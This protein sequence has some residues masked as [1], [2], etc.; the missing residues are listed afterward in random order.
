MNSKY[1]SI[2]LWVAAMLLPVVAH[3]APAGEV[4]FAKGIGT[5]QASGNVPR[6]LSQGVAIEAGDTVTLGSNSFAVVK[7]T[8]GTQMTLRPNTTIKFDD[9][10][11]KQVDKPDSLIASLL[12]G[13]VRM[14][15][16][17][18]AKGSSSAAK[19]NTATATVGIRG[20]DFDARICRTDC[21][22]DSGRI[23]QKSDVANVAASAR[24]V[25]LQGPVSA[26]NQAG[27]H[28]QVAEGGP[29][30]S[31]ET[32]ET[33]NNGHAVLV[34][35]DNTKVSVQSRTQFKVE[36]FVYISDRPG[37]GSVVFNLLRGGMRVLTGLVGKAQPQAMRMTTLTATVGIRGTGL[38]I[39]SEPEGCAVAG[40]AAGCTLITAWEGEGVLNPGSTNELP[41]P[42][43]VF[44]MQDSMAGT[45]RQL[46]TPPPFMLNIPTPRPDAVP[47]NANQLFS[48]EEINESAPGLFVF[49]RDGH[50]AMTTGEKTIDIGRGETGFL[51][52]DGSRLVR[53]ILTPNF[54]EFDFIPRPDRFNPSSARL[55]DLSGA[56]RLKPQVCR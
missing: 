21:A 43:G 2:V 37:E 17:L 52:Q 27:E 32:L 44:A 35:R 9:Y 53:T 14:V 22:N 48:A 19:L 15:T 28:R 1:F 51:S 4:Q 31:G 12:K 38:D 18:I 49:S 25:N 26:T 40:G 7:M 41:V 29:V 20:T 16:G 45:P 6:A 36:N 11:Y 3:P 56:F 10:V 24:V 33:A 55:L 50:L 46:V 47:T 13:G 30:Y 42:T 39:F 5:A 23:P 54:L 8:D 34:F